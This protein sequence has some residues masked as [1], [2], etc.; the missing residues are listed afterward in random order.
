MSV[1][2]EFMLH[3]VVRFRKIDHEEVAWN[4]S[5]WAP[6][7]KN[8]WKMLETF[9]CWWNRATGIKRLS[10]ILSRSGVSFRQSKDQVID[11]RRCLSR[12]GGLFLLSEAKVFPAPSLNRSKRNTDSAT[13]TSQKIQVSSAQKLLF[14]KLLA[15]RQ[16]FFEGPK[17]KFELETAF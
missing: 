14:L 13:G 9:S 3:T 12:M 15:L 7:S 16:T 4:F 10:S 8:D 11:S 5:G 1:L 6:K 17:K 2:Q